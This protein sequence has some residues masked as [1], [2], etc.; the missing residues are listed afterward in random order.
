MRVLPTMILVGSTARNLGKTALATR[1]IEALRPREK[2]VGVKVTT[3]RDRGAGCPRGGEGCGTCSSLT[4]NYEIRE[5][6][7]PDGEKDTSRLLKAGAARV[8]WLKVMRDALAEGLE[9]LMT[10]IDRGAVIV[11]ESNSLRNVVT[12]SLFL[13]LK[14]SG[15]DEVKPTA[16][17][18]MPFVDI[19]VPSANGNPEVSMGD[20]LKTYYSYF[21]SIVLAGGTSRRMGKDKALLPIDGRPMIQSLIQSLVPISR[22][23]I[24]SLNDRERHQQL[25]QVLPGGVRV[26]YD[27]RPGQG[28]LMGIYAGLKASET[29]VNF[30]I[31]CDIPEIDP[32]FITEMRSHTGDHDVVVSVDT[33]GRTNALLAMYRRSVIPLVKKQL[34]EGQRKIILFYPQCRVKYVPLHDGAWY[35]NINTMDDYETYHRDRIDRSS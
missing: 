4:G 3:I 15:C 18:V 27:E 10:H 32:G 19:T 21:T 30:V 9:A 2:V 23:I 29:D 17:D 14:D 13:M 24:V 11:A 8:F 20:I 33:E 26:V 34:D 35:K 25:K 5:E 22:E 28:P 12:P 6:T 7:D 31:A 16:R 1:L